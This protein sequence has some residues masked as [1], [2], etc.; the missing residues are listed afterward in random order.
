VAIGGATSRRFVKTSDGLCT[1]CDFMCMFHSDKW[2]VSCLPL[3]CR[4][5]RH[6][7]TE[8]GV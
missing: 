5:S 3:I 6:E 2:E 1:L 7:Q 8:M 4:G